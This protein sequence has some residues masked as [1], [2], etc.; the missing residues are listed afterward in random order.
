M[1]GAV[2]LV[3]ICFRSAFGLVEC[4]SPS[5]PQLTVGEECTGC[6]FTT[7]DLNSVNSLQNEAGCMAAV[8]GAS[9]Q[10][11]GYPCVTMQMSGN[12]VTSCAV[13]K[14]CGVRNTTNSNKKSC[15][16]TLGGFSGVS[17]ASACPADEVCSLSSSAHTAAAASMVALSLSVF[18]RS[19]CGWPY[20]VGPMVFHSRL[21]S[22]LFYFCPMASITVHYGAT[23]ICT[24]AYFRAYL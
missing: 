13:H 23:L 12:K 21:M 3:T 11:S 9:S 15:L 18:F 16:Y 19:S 22:W 2:V 6:A 1:G 7:V 5:S 17:S 8:A 20:K 10:I 14:S 4:G 24:D